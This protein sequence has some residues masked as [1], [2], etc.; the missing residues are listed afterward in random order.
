MSP[1]AR[2]KMAD[3]MGSEILRNC[4]L[5]RTRQISRVLTAVY[6][7]ALR[8]FGIHA[9]QFTLLVMVH[10]LGPISR[11]DLGRRNH[12]ERSTLTRNLQPLLA[13]GWLV[14]GTPEKDGRTRPLTVTA[15]GKALL[16]KAAPA[17]STA[18]AEARALVGE[19][20]AGAIM[21]IAKELPKRGA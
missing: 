13:Q 5:T 6:D 9:P 18:Q 12:H 11:A 7:D 15:Q 14:E 19:Q 17:W 2:Q 1:A 8:P 21:G 20:G 3:T 16:R 10:E 4:L